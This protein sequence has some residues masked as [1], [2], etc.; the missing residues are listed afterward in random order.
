[1]IAVRVK[2]PKISPIAIAVSQIAMKSAQSP[3]CDDTIPIH[4]LIHAV[5]AGGW[6][7]SASVKYPTKPDENAGCH[8]KNAS[9]AQT[10]PNAIRR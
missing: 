3:G 1:M 6:L 5:I 7:S 8:L 10:S 4:Q 9:S 2:M